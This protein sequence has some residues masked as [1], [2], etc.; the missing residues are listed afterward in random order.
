M[1][2]SNALVSQAPVLFLG[3]VFHKKISAQKELEQFVKR[4]M[5]DCLTSS[6]RIKRRSQD[7]R[8]L[9]ARKWLDDSASYIAHNVMLDWWECLA[10]A[11]FL[12]SVHSHQPGLAWGDFIKCAE[13]AKGYSGFPDQVM[14]WRKFTWKPMKIP[15]AW[16]LKRMKAV[17]R[18]GCNRYWPMLRLFAPL[19]GEKRLFWVYEMIDEFSSGQL[20]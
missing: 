4:H 7:N 18:D 3:S 5:T 9:I 10:S 13:D 20:K 16:W 1:K 8:K 19:P 11:N 15:L 6:Q 2:K 17:C 14:S 12:L